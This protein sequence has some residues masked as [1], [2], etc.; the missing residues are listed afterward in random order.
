MSACRSACH[1]NNYFRKSS[2]SDVSARILVRMSVSVSASWNAGLMELFESNDDIHITF[3]LRTD[4]WL[5]AC[6]VWT[7]PF[8]WV[9]HCRYARCKRFLYKLANTRS[10]EAPAAAWHP[11][12]CLATP[13]QRLYVHS[14]H[15]GPPAYTC[16]SRCSAMNA[17]PPA[18]QAL[19]LI[20]Q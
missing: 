19:S 3:T 16:L 14:R 17:R 10:P 9:G 7:T 8:H 5:R 20:L 13:S 15:M 18:A 4:P 11:S 2:V 1:R 6:I 12:A